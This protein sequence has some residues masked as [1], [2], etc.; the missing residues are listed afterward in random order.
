M[1]DWVLCSEDLPQVEKDRRNVSITVLAR[2]DDGN[3]QHAFCDH[4]TGKWYGVTGKPIKRVIAWQS[5]PEKEK[6]RLTV[7][8][9]KSGT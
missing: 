6:S 9:V 5:L 7:G 8:A 2:Q 3:E 4:R 1:D